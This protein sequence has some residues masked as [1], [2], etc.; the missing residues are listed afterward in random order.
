MYVGT[1]YTVVHTCMNGCDSTRQANLQTKGG[2]VNKPRTVVS[3]DDGGAD[4]L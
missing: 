4:A 2:Q 1:L 3:G